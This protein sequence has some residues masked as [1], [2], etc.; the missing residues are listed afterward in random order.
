MNVNVN[1][2]PSKL[3]DLFNFNLDN[4][5]ADIHEEYSMYV[6]DNADPSEVTICNGD[7]L[8]QATESE[9]LLEEFMYHWIAKIA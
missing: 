6:M 7:T 2:I 4:D 8:L 3:V 9:Y 5:V 1:E